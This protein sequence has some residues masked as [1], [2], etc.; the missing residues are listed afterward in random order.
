MMSITRSLTVGFLAAVLGC[1][2]APTVPRS[3]DRL[4]ISPRNVLAGDE[5]RADAGARDALNAI[6]RLRPWFL[7]QR[8]SNNALPAVFVNGKRY[9]HIMD[10]KTISSGEIHEI[11]YLTAVQASVPFGGSA[12]AI[13]ITTRRHAD[14]VR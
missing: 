12:D 11:R 3:S 8:G 4:F 6:Q 1:A 9:Y 14:H 5:I 7:R 13:V 2:S 10:L